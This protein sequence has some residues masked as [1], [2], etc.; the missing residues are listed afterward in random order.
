MMESTSKHVGQT[1]IIT[2]CI[3]KTQVRITIIKKAF[4]HGS[5]DQT[6]LPIQ[7]L[8]TLVID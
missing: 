1:C 4:W 8:P 7:A 5:V 6:D 3:L 2:L